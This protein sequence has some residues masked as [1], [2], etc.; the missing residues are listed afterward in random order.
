MKKV[1]V[2]TLCLTTTIIPQ[3]ETPNETQIQ[4]Q[5][6]TES[7]KSTQIQEQ[8][9]TETIK[10]Q[11]NVIKRFGS[12]VKKHVCKVADQAHMTTLW[13]ST[14]I[15]ATTALFFGLASLDKH[16]PEFNNAKIALA[17]VTKDLMSLVKT[18]STIDYKEKIDNYLKSPPTICFFATLG[19]IYFGIP[20]LKKIYNQ[21]KTT[22]KKEEA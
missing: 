4:E 1:L 19:T 10:K 6:I 7:P 16:K 18:N 21:S 17:E 20:L 5:K 22:E 13:T 8:K 3:T 15:S 14:T 12:W 2:L 9:E 11:P